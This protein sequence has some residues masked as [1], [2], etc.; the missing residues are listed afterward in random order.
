[1][2]H[3]AP[4]V[5]TSGG[6]VFPFNQLAGGTTVACEGS[7]AGAGGEHIPVSTCLVRQK[8]YREQENSHLEWPDHIAGKAYNIP[9]V[10]QS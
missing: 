2:A 9:W 1:M 8:M 5:K 4:K 7:L 6:Q 10:S 3:T